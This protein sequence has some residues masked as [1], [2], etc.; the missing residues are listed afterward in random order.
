MS[1]AFID[2]RLSLA[3]PTQSIAE[4]R[5]SPCSALTPPIAEK[6]DNRKYKEINKRVDNFQPL[7]LGFHLF[8]QTRYVNSRSLDV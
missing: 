3:R 7:D 2:G 1:F 4:L 6:N 8:L 5:I